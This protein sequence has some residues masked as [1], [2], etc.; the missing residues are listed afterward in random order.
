MR[1][2]RLDDGL[3]NFLGAVHVFIQSYFHVLCV[4]LTLTLLCLLNSDKPNTGHI[5]LAHNRE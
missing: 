5:Y 1:N 2:S 4:P 3:I